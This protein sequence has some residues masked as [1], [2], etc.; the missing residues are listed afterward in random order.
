MNTDTEVKSAKFEVIVSN[1]RRLWIAHAELLNDDGTRAKFSTV[2]VHQSRPE[3]L[4]L[5]ANA[6]K[7]SMAFKETREAAE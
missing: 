6:I 5:L 2:M 7:A 3:A 1:E 4:M